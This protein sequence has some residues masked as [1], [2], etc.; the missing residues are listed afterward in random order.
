MLSPKIQSFSRGSAKLAELNG[1]KFKFEL[2][3][4]GKDLHRGPVREPV[5]PLRAAPHGTVLSQLS[6]GSDYG[7]RYL[8]SQLSIGMNTVTII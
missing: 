1:G 4:D 8:K 5:R 2:L 6:I 7:N 3:Q